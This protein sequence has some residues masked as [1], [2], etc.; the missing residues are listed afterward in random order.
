MAQQRRKE[1]PEAQFSVLLRV[2][3]DKDARGIHVTFCNVG[4]VKVSS[5][6]AASLKTFLCAH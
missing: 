3:W 5:D 2:A 4:Q 6:G 1:I